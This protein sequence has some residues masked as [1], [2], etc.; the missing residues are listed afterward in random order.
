MYNLYRGSGSRPER[1][2]TP[3]PPPRPQ[4]PASPL[5]PQQGGQTANPR[6]PSRGNSRPGQGQPRPNP[7]QRPPN[8]NAGHRGGA[9]PG[10]KREKPKPPERRGLEHILARLDPGKLETEDLLVLAILWLLY[11]DSGDKDLLI[12][13]GA[14]LFL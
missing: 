13:M 11:R 12:A 2:E 10:E 6:Q 5:P 9:P 14:Y 7:G 4:R 1:V 8:T 3:P